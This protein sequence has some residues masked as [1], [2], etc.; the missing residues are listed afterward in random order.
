MPTLSE[1]VAQQRP[2]TVMVR[3]PLRGDLMAEID[4]LEDRMRA[5]AAE[6]ARTNREPIHQVTAQLVLDKRQEMADSEVEFVFRAV[7][8]SVFRRLLRE[9]PPTGEQRAEAEAAG[10]R[11]SF[12]LET[13]PPALMAESCVEPEGA[14]LKS[15]QSIWDE[16]S[17]GATALLW[18]DCFAV[19]QGSAETPPKSVTASVAV[20]ASKLSS[21]TA[22]R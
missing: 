7:P 2:A 1:V 11:L 14:S 19:N 12:N 10:L 3:V 18:R 16:W 9:H 22:P 21:G 20:H 8:R 6:D 13:F 15:F 5:E 4:Q 17:E